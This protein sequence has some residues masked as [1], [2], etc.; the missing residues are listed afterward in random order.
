MSGG[1]KVRIFLC[2]EIMPICLSRLSSVGAQ[3]AQRYIILLH[4]V[5]FAPS[6][7]NCTVCSLNILHLNNRILQKPRRAVFSR[8]I[9]GRVDCQQTPAGSETFCSVVSS[10]V[11]AGALA[12]ILMIG[13][14]G[15]SMT[16]NAESLDF[17]MAAKG[18]PEAGG[19]GIQRGWVACVY[20][21]PYGVGCDFL[22][23]TGTPSPEI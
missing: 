20:S 17:G 3:Q 19:L 21:V 14:P 23:S 2:R 12:G 4:S 18:T 22:H 1:S 16:A 5:G 10:K 7:M 15:F 11:A 9:S 13:C 6:T 8:T